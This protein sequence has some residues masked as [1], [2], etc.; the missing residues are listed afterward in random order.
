MIINKLKPGQ[1]AYKDIDGTRMKNGNAGVS[2]TC[3]YDMDGNL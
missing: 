1:E 3:P 2:S